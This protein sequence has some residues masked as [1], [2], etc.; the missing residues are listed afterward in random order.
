MLVTR[1]GPFARAAVAAGVDRIFVDLEIR[2]KR[3]RQ[4]GRTT[5][6]SGHTVEDVSAMRAAVP[7]AEVLARID[8][9]SAATPAEVDAVIDAGADVVM[10]PYFTAVD[11]VARFVE[12]VRGRARTSLLLETTPALARLD[13]ILELGGIDEV[14]VGLNDLHAGLGLTFMYELLAGGVLDHVAARIAA[15]GRRIRFGFGGGAL[16]DAPHPVAPADVLREHLRLGSRMIIL[17]KTFTGD[18]TSLA[19]PARH[20]DLAAE[21]GKIRD[22]VA[23]ARRRTAA[24]IEADRVRIHARIWQ[25]TRDLR[26]RS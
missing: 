25:A 13:G 7:S 8:P 17:S 22:A 19:E 21:I 24:E 11:E 6:I 20:I 14:H 9:P 10:L 18:A 15:C 16:I 4:Q 12:A 26:A 3:E 5:V 1:D 23:A 2:G